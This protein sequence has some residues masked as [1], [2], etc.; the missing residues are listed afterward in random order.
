MAHNRICSIPDCD[1]VQQARTYCGMH[2]RRWRLNGDPTINRSQ[3]RLPCSIDGCEKLRIG[4][5]YC[6][7]HYQRFMKFGDAEYHAQTSPGEPGEY[8]NSVVLGH[9]S[10]E[11]LI[12]PFCRTGD[13]YGSIRFEGSPKLVTRLVCEK[14]HGRPPTDEHEAAH[15]CGNG[16][17][18][19]CS[20]RHLRW[21]TRIENQADRLSHGTSPRGENCG[22][23][24]LTE[25][26]V[27]EIR[28]GLHEKDAV[29]AERYGIGR[30]TVSMIQNKKAWAWLD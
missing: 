20:P 30:S 7:K 12:W 19:C 10:D 6:S 26:D 23:A 8:L 16:H 5:G 13:G 17:L 21:A 4:H 15:S 27:R 3:V 11:C 25:R 28:A 2:Y 18:G 22:K 14:V 9:S 24:K 29:L 1:K